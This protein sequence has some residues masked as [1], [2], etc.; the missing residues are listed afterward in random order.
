MNG[1]VNTI[2]QGTTTHTTTLDPTWRLRTW[3]TSA[4][5]TATQ[6]SHYSSD[7]DS[8]SWISENTANTNWTRNIPGIDGLLAA[9]EPNAGPI[10]Y[11]LS[12]LHGDVAATADASGS[13]TTTA[14]YQEFGTP[15]SGTTN[16][17]GWLGV[18]QRQGDTSS[19]DILMGARTYVPSVGRFLQVDPVAGG[20]ASSTITQ[21]V[22]PLTAPTYLGPRCMLRES[23]ASRTFGATSSL[24]STSPD[25]ACLSGG[26]RILWG[27]TRS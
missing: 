17:Y 5:S 26:E 4:D 25:I 16:R 21:A 6:T 22:I 13:I 18:H 3:A 8:P 7:T 12:N 11:Q 27:S 14:D 15:R 9:T 20:S 1:Q 24:I 23:A 10:T 2:T 19:G